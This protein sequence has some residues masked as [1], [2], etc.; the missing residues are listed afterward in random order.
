M[1]TWNSVVESSADV[2]TMYTGSLYG[3]VSVS[4]FTKIFGPGVRCGWIE[5]DR[6]IIDAVQSIGY[7][8]SQ[9]AVGPVMGS[10]LR[11]GLARGIVDCVLERLRQTYQLRCNLLCNILESEKAIELFCRPTGGYFVWIRTSSFY[12]TNDFLMHCLEHGIRFMP[13]YKCDCAK[14]I[15][16][17]HFELNSSLKFYARLCFAKLNNNEI[18]DGAKLFLKCF[19]EYND[20][21]S[22]K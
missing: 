7:I 2:S 21:V 17:P 4:S 18:E 10:V 1:V 11:L 6:N 14:E 19:R 20:K 3:C 13:G 12:I 5:A 8:Q 16:S 22:V 9:G 15:S